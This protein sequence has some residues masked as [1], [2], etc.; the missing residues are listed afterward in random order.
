MALVVVGTYR[1]L[2]LRCG[3]ARNEQ[4]FQLVMMLIFRGFHIATPSV[5]IFANEKMADLALDDGLKGV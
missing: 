5:P 2:P 1:R 3:C 4:N